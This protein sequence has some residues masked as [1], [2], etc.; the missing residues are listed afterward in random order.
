MRRS[1]TLVAAVGATLALAACSGGST[2]DSSASPAAEETSAAADGGSLTIWVDETR[3][4]AVEA[5]A[6]K[7]EEETGASV[8]T[9]LKNFD[10]IRAD[11]NAQVPTGK[12]PDITVGA[13]DWL[14]ELTANGVA[15]PIELG[16]KAAEFEPVAVEAFSKDGQ[17]YG[18]PYAVEN[19][20]LIRNTALAAE[21]P[22]TWDD[23]VA[24]GKAAG[25]TYPILLQM[26]EEG[27]PYTMYPL[28]T[29]FG[30]PVFTQNDDGTYKPEL[31]LGGEAGNAFAQ[32]LAAQGAAGVLDPAIT[33]DIAVEAF[34]KGESPFIVGGPWMIASFK[35]L[36][37]AIDPIP[38]AGG[39]PAQP[40]VG[41]AGF[42][43]NAQ[44]DNSL[45]ANDFLVNYMATEEA[46]LALYEAGDRPP[47]LIAA[48]D[49]ASENPVTAGFRDVGADALPM[50]SI[51]EMGSV[52]EFW[53][54]TEAAI[55]SGAQEP[56]AAWEKMVADIQGALGA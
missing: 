55:V 19:I 13:H 48:A 41:V 21:A 47:A 4:P 39:Q 9:V 40:F 25:T 56:V 26:G 27:D 22:A 17:V 20:A 32:F 37:L 50:P 28:Q 7:F 15:A 31:A 16:D 11:F 12:G 51:P 8:E 14:G 23:A 52:W 3:Q 54:V 34:A 36:D 30:A 10:D 18:L 43:V 33:Y 49:A 42:Y 24:A 44:S 35:D 45:L 1:I 53:G 46:Q 29:S 2:D 6:A 5:A 38:S